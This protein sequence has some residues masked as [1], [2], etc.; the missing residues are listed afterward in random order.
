[1]PVSLA[2]PD[3]HSQG[4]AT[5]L[6]VT[7]C[8]RDLKIVFELINT[9]LKLG[10]F[11]SQSGFLHF[12]GKWAVLFSIEPMF[13]HSLWRELGGSA[14]W[15]WGEL[16]FSTVGLRCPPF[17]TETWVVPCHSCTNLPG[18]WGHVVC[19]PSIYKNLHLQ[20]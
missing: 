2:L 1:M 6:V 17:S 5:P 3:S 19:D 9:L 11:T 10:E 20:N 7:V 12:L 18:S 14:R 15:W 8:S 13:L 16:L 4:T